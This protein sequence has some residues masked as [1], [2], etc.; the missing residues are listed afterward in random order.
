MRASSAYLLQFFSKIAQIIYN[1]PLHNPT[2]ILRDAL[3]RLTSLRFVVGHVD[4]RGG[5]INASLAIDDCAMQKQD[6][7]LNRHGRNPPRGGQKFGANGSADSDMASVKSEAR[8]DDAHK[9]RN[10]GK[11]ARKVDEQFDMIIVVSSLDFKEILA[12][13]RVTLQKCCGRHLET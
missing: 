13:V 5:Q 11:H 8:F 7:I 2:V 6:Q 12:K 3:E 1:T 9:W 10:G 4:K